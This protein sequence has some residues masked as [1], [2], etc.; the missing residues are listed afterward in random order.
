MPADA[1]VDVEERLPPVFWGDTSEEHLGGALVVEVLIHDFVALGPLN[2][3]RASATSVGRSP[4]LRKLRKGAIQSS[5]LFGGI[6]ELSPNLPASLVR[7]DVVQA[8]GVPWCLIELD[9]YA[10]VSSKPPAVRLLA[11]S[12]GVV[13]SHRLC[14]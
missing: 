13:S 12:P 8:G 7:D 11:S 3:R 2:H 1:D 10:W 4:H 5:G 6:G 14:F 9:I